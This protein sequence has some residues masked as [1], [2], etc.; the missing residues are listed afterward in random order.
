MSTHQKLGS[1]SSLW[2]RPLLNQ[3]QHIVFYYYIYLKE[4]RTE[5]FWKGAEIPKAPRVC[6]PF[7]D[8]R[9]ERRNERK[10]RFCYFLSVFTNHIHK[11]MTWKA[12]RMMQIIVPSLEWEIDRPP[13]VGR[14]SIKWERWHMFYHFYNRTFMIKRENRSRLEWFWTYKTAFPAVGV[15]F[16]SAEW[17]MRSRR[18]HFLPWQKLVASI[19]G[20]STVGDNLFHCIR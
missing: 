8:S 16:W 17:D 20:L 10:E 18:R 3:R 6:A 13:P 1:P 14:L 12:V 15:V 9:K 4:L 11:Y 2:A 7:V 19:G 5:C